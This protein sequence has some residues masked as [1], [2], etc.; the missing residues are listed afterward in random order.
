MVEAFCIK[1]AIPPA[2]SNLMNLALDEV[3]SN[4][5]KY[6]YNAGRHGSIDVELGYAHGRLT[7]IVEDTG[8]PFDP[9]KFRRPDNVG[10][11]SERKQGGL[12]ILFVKR[13]VD[14]VLYDRTG[15]RNKLTLT[16]KVPLAQAAT[17]Q[18][19]GHR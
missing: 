10:P 6:A 12:G 8:I 4:I 9:L 16:I 5:V 17:E 18:Q 15:G 13:L 1:N 14:S 19:D 2:T 7:A 3:L 11:L